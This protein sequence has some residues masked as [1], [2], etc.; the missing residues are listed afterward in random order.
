MMEVSG[1]R[2]SLL[3]PSGAGYTHFLASLSMPKL[4]LLLDLGGH[5]AGDERYAQHDEN[6]S[7]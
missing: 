5:R 4:L 1:V 6:V 2:M 3:R 7:G